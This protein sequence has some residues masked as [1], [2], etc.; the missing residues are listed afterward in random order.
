MRDKYNLN[1]LPAGMQEADGDSA[2][3]G[4]SEAASA[5]STAVPSV[6][7]IIP[8]MAPEDRVTP[9]FHKVRMYNIPIYRRRYILVIF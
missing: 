9:S 2:A 7:S 4:A 3:M 1:T 6:Q 8:G 5:A